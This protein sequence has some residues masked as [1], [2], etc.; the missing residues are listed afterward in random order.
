MVVKRVVG[1]DTSTAIRK[2][3]SSCSWADRP[4]RPPSR[5][6]EL[7]AVGAR[8]LRFLVRAAGPRRAGDRRIM[9]R[10]R[11]GQPRPRGVAPTM[12]RRAMLEGMPTE[13]APG[14]RRTADRA[15]LASLLPT[16][17]A[18]YPNGASWLDRRVD[19]ALRGRAEVMVWG[20]GG[21]SDGICIE[22]PKGHRRLKLS[23]L[24]VPPLARGRG[25]GTR[26]L[27]SRALTWLHRGLQ[28]VYVTVAAE[29]PATADFFLRH[30]FI[31]RARCAGR[32]GHGRDELVLGWDPDVAARTFAAAA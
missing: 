7:E 29:D 13:L 21:R 3:A 22:T 19:D 14:P 10:I 27:Q 17:Q 6:R 9:R 25:V 31:H 1:W 4:K 26:L 24:F 18:R 30:G 5:P 8:C 11:A 12:T 23:T 28:D 32:Y 16:L 2:P 15:G 20:R